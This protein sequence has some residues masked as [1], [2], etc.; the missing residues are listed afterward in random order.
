MNGQQDE[1]MASMMKTLTKY[2]NPR[3]WE[4]NPVA[5]NDLPFQQ[6]L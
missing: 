1:Q 5:I 3:V 6:N 2:M 4:I